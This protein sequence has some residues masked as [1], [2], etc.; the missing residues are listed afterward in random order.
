[1]ITVQSKKTLTEK[2]VRRHPEIL[3]RKK[4]F[5]EENYSICRRI[6]VVEH[7]Q[8]REKFNL[9]HYRS[10]KGKIP[11]K[12]LWGPKAINLGL[13]IHRE[14][15]YHPLTAIPTILHSFRRIYIKMYP[16]EVL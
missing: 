14:F 12:R 15:G 10:G 4:K 11:N 2:V 13:K 3:K 9:E 6:F 8:F 7:A 16:N 5:I 1:V